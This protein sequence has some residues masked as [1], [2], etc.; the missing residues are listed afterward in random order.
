M[1]LKVVWVNGTILA[2]NFTNKYAQD[3]GNYGFD[4]D[5]QR[6]LTVIYEVTGHCTGEKA[7]GA[8]AG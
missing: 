6:E 1:L 3:R 4:D 7:L 2:R 8:L 5:L